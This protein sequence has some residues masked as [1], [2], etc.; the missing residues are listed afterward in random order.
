MLFVTTLPYLPRKH[1]CA[2][3]RKVA[4]WIPDWVIGIIHQ[5]NPFG[6]S[7]ALESSEP[8]TEVSTRSIS[9]GLKAVGA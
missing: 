1:H 9:W 4:G 5:F 2:T 7:I 8:L 3:S 6:R